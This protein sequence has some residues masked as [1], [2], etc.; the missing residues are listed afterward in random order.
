MNIE[1]KAIRERLKHAWVPFFGKFGK[2]TAVQKMTIPKILDGHNVVV[3]SPTASGKTEAVVA[4]VA[5]KLS[6][7]RWK[8]TAAILAVVYVVP[9][10]AL[11]ND[12]YQRIKD[13][14]QD[15]H[16]SV[17]IKHGDRQHFRKNIPPNFLITTPETL[18]SLICRSPII[19]ENLRTLIIDEVHFIDNTYRGDQLRILIKRLNTLVHN[20]FSIHLLSATIS[21]PAEIGRR[22]IF[23][24]FEVV[25]VEGHRNIQH[26]FVEN[27]EELFQLVKEKK[28]K[29]ILWFCNYR[30]STEKVAEMIREKWKIFPVVVHHGNLSRRHREDGE[31]TMRYESKGVCVATSTLEVGIDVGNIDLIVIG[32]LPYSV[33][34]LLQRIGRGNRR[35]DII[36][37]AAII[38]TSEE[39]KLLEKMLEI[40]KSGDILEESYLPDYSVCVQ[41][42]F[43]MLYQ[44]RSGK[45]ER[46]ITEM[47]SPLLDNEGVSSIL[48]H[49]EKKEWLTFEREKW[50]ATQKLMDF[51]ERG[52]IH[53]NI[54]SE[55]EFNVV[56]I[57]S[58]R[59]IGRISNEFD[60]VFVLGGIV[61]KVKCVEWRSKNN[62][63]IRV[64]RVKEKNVNVPHFERRKIYGRFYYLLPPDIKAKMSYETYL[65]E[66]E[67][68]EFE[69]V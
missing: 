51:G 10:R 6:E 40:S 50:F 68:D 55:Q 31:M 4:P 27:H 2:L 62:I 58:G 26:Y 57:E 52:A 43:S 69:F 28:W 14:L 17:G 45:S 23:G 59:E 37:V 44:C 33:S 41:Q 18:D 13:P 12:I 9:T 53:S 11:A 63:I 34:S 60:E 22:Y 36:D 29:K 25:K 67:D 66:S 56:D 61:W 15:M 39:K 3:S 42:I 8:D 49:L 54:P 65:G 5:E 24:Q 16:I 21:S 35:K 1:E 64:Q 19:F 48:R 32:E 7:E 20:V 46:E 30:E 47:L 38:N